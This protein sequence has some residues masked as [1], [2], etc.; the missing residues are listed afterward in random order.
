MKVSLQWLESHL[1][2]ADFSIEQL[3]DLLTFS[4]IEVEG[5]ESLPDHLVVAQILSSEPHPG[6]D[7]LSVCQVDDGSGQTRQIVCGAK[8]YRVGDKVPLALPGCVLTA[9]DGKRF[10]IREGKL[11]GVDSLGMMCSA[12][13][14]GL[15]NESD[16]L[17][18]LD[19]EAKS[20]APMA[21]LYP[22]VF[23]LE[24][25]PNRPDCLSHLGVARELAAL[26][27]RPLKGRGEYCD[28]Q[29]TVRPGESSELRL[30]TA[31]CTF[32]TARIIRGVRVTESPA[33]LKQRL[34][35]IGLRP[36]NNIVDLTNYVLFETGQPLHVFDLAK[37]EGAVV[38]RQASEGEAL[39]AL[40]GKEYILSAK[41]VVIADEHKAL[42]IGGV[43]GGEDSG[44]TGATTDIL[45]EVA[46]FDPPS[47]RH[48]SRRLAL[49]SDSSY[50]FERGVD[51]LQVMGNSELATR[52]IEE[53]S[54]GKA[55]PELLTVGSPGEPPASIELDGDLC[56]AVIGAPVTDPEIAEVLL[57]LGL[58]KSTTGW[59]IPSYRRDLERPIDLIEE[60]ARIRGLDA[61]PAS[62]RSIY[63]PA[64]KAD[65]AYDFLCS[66][67]NR[68]VAL[69]F[70]ETRSLKLISAA[71][72]ND[73]LANQ[74]RGMNPL[75]LKNPLN[76]EQ[77]YLRSGLLPGLL[78]TAARN[79][80]FGQ[81][82]LRLFEAGRVFTAT[83]KGDE[84]EH[85]HLALL[86]TG[87]RNPRSWAHDGAVT[88]DLHDLRA[89]LDVVC[90]QK[91]NLTPLPDGK[92][93]CACS[94]ELGSGKKAVKL[95]SAGILPPARARELDLPAPVV[96]A[97]LDL[98]KLMTACSRERVFAELSRFPGSSRDVAILAPISLAAGELKDFIETYNE[99]LLVSVELFDVFADPTGSKLPADKKSLAFSLL[100]RREDRTLEASEVEASHAKLL[101]SIRQKFGVEF[102]Q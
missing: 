58:K 50:R 24:I 101:D 25:T 45:L 37:L 8:N 20:G 32:Y 91:V 35:S 76:D 72:L 81:S 36:I 31:G 21:E 86:L 38:I 9:P 30:E 99:P 39:L 19:P 61:V 97:E 75:R 29:T 55:D 1:D 92:L 60:V 52:L 11:R 43:M 88:L 34:E 100:Y 77:D 3:C 7:K 63:T 15:A 89:A 51:P 12:Q 67:R 13:E 102:R 64:S 62:N 87:T 14:L 59:E 74:Y 82:N 5:V 90:G 83:P 79:Q 80:R 95:G 22:T 66:L 84:I 2:L 27:R 71:Q 56:R 85:E 57:A 33:W 41:D 47:I 40:D 4:G 54:G 28:S 48:T 94:I 17:L 10:E 46:H 69:G 42:A 98:K 68:L 23:E 70:F 53:L 6:A 73:D 18:I 44:V 96:L 16:G 65:L 26:L 78:A 49:H 93:M